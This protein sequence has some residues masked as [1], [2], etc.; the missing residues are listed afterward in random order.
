MMWFC[1]EKLRNFNIF[2]N[3]NSLV[4]VFLFDMANTNLFNI[5]HMIVIFGTLVLNNSISSKF[6]HFLKSWFLG[7]LRGKR[8]KNDLKLPNSVCFVPYLGK[9][10]SDH[11]DFNNDIYRCFSLYFFKKCNI[12]N[13]NIILFLLAH[14][15]SF[16][17]NNLFSKFINKCQKEIEVCPMIITSVWFFKSKGIITYFYGVVC[18]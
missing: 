2:I 13:I 8:A 9:C 6:F 5:H 18:M 12:I 11:Q 3:N 1:H 4:L 10:R 17:N 15:N 16:F 7:F 14:F